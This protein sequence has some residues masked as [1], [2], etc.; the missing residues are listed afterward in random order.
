MCGLLLSIY[1]RQPRAVLHYVTSCQQPVSPT[2]TP[3]TMPTACQVALLRN[4]TNGLSALVASL[5]AALKT[6][7]GSSGKAAGSSSRQVRS[8]A[9]PFAMHT[10]VGPVVLAAG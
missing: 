5:K 4:Y 2:S 8:Y 6:S 10:P 9:G 1:V 3:V 7:S